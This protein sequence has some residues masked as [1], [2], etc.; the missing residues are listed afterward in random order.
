MAPVGGEL[1]T[2]ERLRIATHDGEILEVWPIGTR[3]YAPEAPYL[4][5]TIRAHEYH[6]SGVISPWPYSIEWD[7]PQEAFRVFGWL[8]MYAGV[9]G[10]APILDAEAQR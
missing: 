4:T 5:G 2:V 6:E 9:N 10:V 7:D 1:M 3:I 8:A